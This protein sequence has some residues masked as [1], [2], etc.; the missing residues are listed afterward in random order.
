[1]AEP[2][3][4]L[5]RALITYTAD[6]IV[7]PAEIAEALNVTTFAV[8]KWGWR[9]RRGGKLGCPKPIRKLQTG[10]IYSLRDWEAWHKIWTLTH[11]Q[12]RPGSR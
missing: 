7:G 1:M 11:R 5:F 3:R 12:A 10:Y 9:D 4:P 6:D 8:R 2:E